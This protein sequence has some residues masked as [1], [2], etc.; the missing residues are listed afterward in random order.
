MVSPSRKLI[1]REYPQKENGLGFLSR[2]SSKHEKPKEAHQ[3]QVKG[4]NLKVFELCIAGMSSPE[5]CSLRQRHKISGRT[6]LVQELRNNL[7]PN[8]GR[9]QI[10]K[11]VSPGSTALLASYSLRTAMRCST[12]GTIITLLYHITIYPFRVRQNWSPLCDGIHMRWSKQILWKLP[13][14]LTVMSL[15]FSSQLSQL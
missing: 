9:K 1:C 13:S 8:C 4:P 2:R 14:G 10:S 3:N 7:N 12:W 15:M 6:V 5:A 11:L